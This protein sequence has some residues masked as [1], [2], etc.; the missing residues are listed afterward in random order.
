MKLTE[1]KQNGTKRLPFLCVNDTIE[2][3]YIDSSLLAAS[4]SRS[5]FPTQCE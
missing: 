5:L 4:L 1:L 3:A 2:Y